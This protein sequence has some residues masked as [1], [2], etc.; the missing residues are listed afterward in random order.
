MFWYVV[1]GFL[2]AFGLLCALWVAFGLLLPARVK[3]HAAVVCSAGSEIW[4][5]R[6]FCR[7][8]ELGLTKSDLTILD[9][10]LTARQRRVIQ[11]RYPF[12]HFSTFTSWQKGERTYFGTGYG[13]SARHNCSCS[14]SEL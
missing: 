3:C 12:I 11:K 10:G 1:F 5:I 8:R 7:L 6:R 2:A 9:C 13:D 14:I 4:V